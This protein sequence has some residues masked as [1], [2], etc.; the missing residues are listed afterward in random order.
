[1]EGNGGGGKGKAATATFRDAATDRLRSDVEDTQQ[2][3]EDLV[4]EQRDI[5]VRM[6]GLAET[7]LGPESEAGRRLF[8]RITC[9]RDVQPTVGPTPS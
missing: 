5:E 1:M 9:E 8:D 2:R 3:A 4:R 6:D 7:N